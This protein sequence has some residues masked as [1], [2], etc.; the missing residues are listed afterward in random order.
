VVEL[1]GPAE[2]HGPVECTLASYPR[3]FA[4]SHNFPNPASITTT[5]RFV[6]PD[7]CDITISIYDVAGRKVKTVNRSS[8]PAGENEIEV[9]VATL[10]PG[11]YTYRLE[12]G[13]AA[14]ARRMVVVK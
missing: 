10:V 13:G 5:I 2:R 9:D 4:L 8:V 7:V 6:V 12:A 3:A 14:A 1:G 11:V